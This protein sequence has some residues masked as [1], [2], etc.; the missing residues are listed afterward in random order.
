MKNI[1][2][3]STEVELSTGLIVADGGRLLTNVIQAVAVRLC[4]LEETR[5]AVTAE[6]GRVGHRITS[7]SSRVRIVYASVI[8]D[9]HI[10]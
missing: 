2:E 5:K 3:N 6:E 1:C 10:Q 7:R 4:H 9:T 8:E